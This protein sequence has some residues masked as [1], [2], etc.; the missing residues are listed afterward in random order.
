VAL[1]LSS[2]QEQ[3]SKLRQKTCFSVSVAAA[4]GHTVCYILCPEYIWTHMFPNRQKTEPQPP[5]TIKKLSNFRQHRLHE[6]RPIATDNLIAWCVCQSKTCKRGTRIKV[7]SVDLSS[8]YPRITR[9]LRLIRISQMMP[10]SIRLLLKY[11]SRLFLHKETSIYFKIY[12][13][14][15]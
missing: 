11:F 6:I 7:L 8:W 1:R 13:I 2:S 9:L 15:A 4:V 14:L 10:H 12:G 5:Q 3:H